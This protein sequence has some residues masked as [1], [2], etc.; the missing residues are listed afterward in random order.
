[1]RETLYKGVIVRDN[2]TIISRYGKEI[3][4]KNK[5][6]YSYLKLDG[7][8]ILKHRLI[9]EAFNGEIPEGMEIDHITPL[10]EGGSDELSNLRLVTS[11]ENKNNPKTLEK[12]KISNK[13][14]PHT[15]LQ[16]NKASMHM[17]LLNTIRK[18]HK[19]GN[20]C[21]S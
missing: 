10:S 6:G 15:K 19:N 11:K 20:V 3:G 9:W 7:K 14:K 16:R 17:W 5:K 12:Y 8:Q 2:G 18:Y 4:H 13:N 1:M 21:K